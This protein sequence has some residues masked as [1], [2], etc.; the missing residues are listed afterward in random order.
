MDHKY[1]T[2]IV[3]SLS[4]TLYI[5]MTNDIERRMSQH[6]SEE[7][8]G[9]AHQYSCNR[10]VYYKAID[11]PLNAIAREKQLKGWRRSKKIALIE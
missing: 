7:F 2:Y 10:L 4:S 8:E 11:N 9:F 3:A 1:W 5:S 6:K